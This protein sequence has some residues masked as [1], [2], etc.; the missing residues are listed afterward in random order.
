MVEDAVRVF[1]NKPDPL[2]AH[3]ATLFAAGRWRRVRA[4]LAALFQVNNQ[5][6]DGSRG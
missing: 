6:D 3:R 1:E 5:A 4:G 2:C